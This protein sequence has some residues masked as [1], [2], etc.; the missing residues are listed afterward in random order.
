LRRER[1]RGKSLARLLRDSPALDPE[2]AS[3]F[4]HKAKASAYNP[5][6]KTNRLQVLPKLSAVAETAMMKPFLYLCAGTLF[7]LV[8]VSATGLLVQEAAP[9]PASP[10]VR[11]PVKTTPESQAHAKKL[12]GVDCEICH[13]TSGDGKTDLAK[14]MQLKLSDWTDPNSLAAKSDKDLF[15]I[16]RNGKDKMPPE[17]ETRAKDAEVWHLVAYIRSLSKAQADT[18]AKPS[19]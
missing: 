3:L 6:E 7:A 2:S 9:A 13:G 17:I 16:I 8:P 11:N 19:N 4:R 1:S 15:D 12:Y 5:G 18:S 14:D 10:S